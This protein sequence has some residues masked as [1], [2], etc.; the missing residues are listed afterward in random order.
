MYPYGH[1]LKCYNRDMSKYYGGIINKI[2]KLAFLFLLSITVDNVTALTM[3]VLGAAETNVIE[4]QEIIEHV[5]QEMTA[6]E[7]QA[8]E[9]MESGEPMSE[10]ERDIAIGAMISA[11]YNAWK[12]CGNVARGMGI[13][14]CGTVIASGYQTIKSVYN[15]IFG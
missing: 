14:G 7:I 8:I 11:L 2:K 12:I 5:S 10:K 3:P 13:P 9:D 4:S 1:T 6:E 15:R